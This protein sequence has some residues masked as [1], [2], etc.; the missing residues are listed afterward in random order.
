[1]TPYL[2]PQLEREMQSSK[3]ANIMQEEKMDNE[4]GQFHDKPIQP[5][6]SFVEKMP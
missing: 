1:M 3:Y 5:L 4:D 2:Y 6:K